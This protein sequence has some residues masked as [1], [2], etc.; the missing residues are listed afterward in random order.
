M[1]RSTPGRRTVAAALTIG[2]LLALAGVARAEPAP[3]ASGASRTGRP[4]APG[5]EATNATAGEAD[6]ESPATTAPVAPTSAEP[7]AET[8]T[9]PPRSAPAPAPTPSAVP[10][11]AAA[12]T[13]AT[14]LAAPTAL[15]DP[16]AT[17]HVEVEVARSG[18]WL[19]L[20]PTLGGEG[21]T[22]ACALPCST[23]LVVE[24]REARVTGAG[25]T[26]SNPFFI[27]PG[28]GI[29]RL[30]ARP[31]SAHARRYGMV[32][33]AT[34]IPLVLA[35]FTGH[36]FGQLEE[37]PTLRDGGV[38]VA[39]LGAAAVVAALPLLAAGATRVRDDRG[40]R[41]ATAP[42]QPSAL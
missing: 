17:A 30:E 12:T 40:R 42:A 6:V 1:T 22:R 28:R 7:P 9:E 5:G 34:G 36:A 10:S 8:R 39:A 33:L 19:E 20:R 23:T 16:L 32:A 2:A 4:T 21:W 29:A 15:T 38:A 25:V 37:S 14:P 35:G 41:V 24:G 18:C 27:E 26:P 31:G 13:A 11:A 3:A